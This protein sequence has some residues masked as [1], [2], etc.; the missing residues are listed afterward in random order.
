MTLPHTLASI[1]ARILGILGVIALGFLLVIAMAQTTAVA[2]HEHMERVSTSLFPASSALNEAE[3]AFNRVRKEYKDA[4]TLEDPSAVG[5]AEKAS[6]DVRSALTELSSRLASFPTYA[7]RAKMLWDHFQR[8]DSESQQTYGAL[9]ASKGN[10]SDDLQ[11][12]AAELAGKNQQF[13][14]DL[15]ALDVAIADESR[16][17]FAAVD[18]SSARSQIIGWVALIVALMGCAGAWGVLRYKVFLPLL[19]LARR[20]QDIAEGDGDLTGRVEVHGHDELDEVAIWFNVFIERIE[21]VVL[22]VASNAQVL[23]DAAKG[24]AETARDTA[25]ATEQQQ[26]QALNIASSMSEISIAVKEISQSTQHAAIDARKAEKNAQSGGE[27]I[28][29]TV[30]S[31]R[32]LLISKE[33]TSA[34]VVELGNASQAIGKIVEI[35][36]DIANQ[37]SLLALN[38]SIE[39]ARAGEHGRGFAVVAGEVRRLAERT[40]K[41]TKEIGTTVRAIQDGTHEVVAAMESG[42]RYV[43][44]GVASARS[45][46]DA[47][48][49]IIRGS[50]AMQFMVT[51]IAGASSEQSAAT[52][53]VNANLNEIANIG[54]RT[55][56]SSARVVEACDS[57]AALAEDLNQLV[58]TFKVDGSPHDPIDRPPT[59]KRSSTLANRSHSRPKQSLEARLR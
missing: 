47:L 34:K 46:G 26:H 51:Q 25:R 31:L 36:D 19:R 54:Q 22:R 28:Q 4:I 3:E 35:I 45:A 58:G 17:E 5:D 16:A 39:S 59:T 29:A 15:Q 7:P 43:E 52:Q 53:S 55:T 57:L 14:A 8:I 1:K 40:S 10:L 23:A 42:M 30:D 24:L 2:T 41:A 50:E 49:S 6:G 38:A 56:S 20:M 32:E 27:T 13:D 44:G 21:R 11:R 12:K 33:A 9:V 18:A 37:T 48:A